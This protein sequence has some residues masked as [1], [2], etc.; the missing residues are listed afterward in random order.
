[1]GTPDDP[2]IHSPPSV[3]IS[4][5]NGSTNGKAY[6]SGGSKMDSIMCSKKPHLVII[7][8]LKFFSKMTR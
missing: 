5:A 8:W 1:M 3:R 6:A 4:S 7:F 2:I